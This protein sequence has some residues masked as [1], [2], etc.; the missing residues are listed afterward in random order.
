[1]K[2]TWRVTGTMSGKEVTLRVEAKDHNA[3][4][5]KGSQKRLVV[6]DCVLCAA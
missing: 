6:R 1:M 3:A 2:K 5:R 4:V